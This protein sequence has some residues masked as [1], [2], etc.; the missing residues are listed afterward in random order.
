LRYLTSTLSSLL[1]LVAVLI[2]GS[3]LP[4]VSF[5]GID[6]IAHFTLFAL[7]AVCVRRDFSQG[8]RWQACLLAGL[9]F[10]VLTEVLQIVVEG[11]TFDLTDLIADAAGLVFGL[12]IGKFFLKWIGRYIG[13]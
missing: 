6:K 7:W 11:R 9:I 1:I 4:D 5:V 13:L 2:P 12:T 8:F 3:Q 10:S